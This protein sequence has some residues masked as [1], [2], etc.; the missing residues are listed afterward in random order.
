MEAEGSEKQ[1][2]LEE[3]AAG[4]V[5]NPSA[6][7]SCESYGPKPDEVDEIT[8]EAGI[9]P[10]RTEVSSYRWVI[11]AI[12]IGLNGVISLGQNGFSPIASATATACGCSDAYVLMIGTTYLILFLPS[13]LLG[14]YMY[15]YM[16][17]HNVLKL[18]GIA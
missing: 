2:L 12:Y 9:E 10:I 7:D 14:N 13:E 5:V 17:I 18:A 3:V 15:K 8:E 6:H 11:L 4:Q 16:K 1:K